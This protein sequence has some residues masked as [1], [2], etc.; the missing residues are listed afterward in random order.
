MV[1]RSSRKR[2]RRV[3]TADSVADDDDFKYPAESESDEELIPP[4]KRS[5]SARRPNVSRR[6][7]KGTG[8]NTRHRRRV[9]QQETSTTSIDADDTEAAAASLLELAEAIGPHTAQRK[10]TMKSR[11]PTQRGARD[12]RTGQPQ[13][14][15]G[16]PTHQ[17]GM[18]MNNHDQMYHVAQHQQQQQQNQ[19]KRCALHVRIAYYIF[20]AQ[21]RSQLPSPLNL[22][23][24][25]QV[26]TPLSLDP[27]LEA[28]LLKERNEPN[29]TGQQHIANGT[30]AAAAFMS[31]NMRRHP[32]EA[33]PKPP[34]QNAHQ[35]GVPQSPAGRTHQMAQ[36]PMH[37]QMMHQRGA[38]P[39][40]VPA[41]P[42]MGQKFP[43]IA[44]PVTHTNTTQGAHLPPINTVHSNFMPGMNNYSHMMH[45]Q[46]GQQ[47]AHNRAGMPNRAGQL[48][49]FNSPGPKLQ[50]PPL[51]TTPKQTSAPVQLPQ[52]HGNH[53]M[54][55]MPGQPALKKETP[56]NAAATPATEAY[57]SGRGLPSLKNL[58]RLKPFAEIKKPPAGAPNMSVPSFDAIKNPQP[59]ELPGV[60]L[61]KETSANVPTLNPPKLEV[62]Q[63]MPATTPTQ[64]PTQVVK[65]EV[66]TPSTTPATT[67]KP[68]DSVVHN[69]ATTPAATNG[70]N[71]LVKEVKA[72]VEQAKTDATPPATDSVKQVVPATSE[73]NEAAAEAP[74][75]ESV[76]AEN[77]N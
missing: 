29:A 12:Q 50:L 7:P 35:H 76:T 51:S 38:Q 11:G 10:T 56:H 17:Q 39:N 67:E 34:V 71:E 66:H 49:S 41:M 24:Q 8:Y 2:A 1:L 9:T 63:T 27:T 42:P 20:Y 3:W 65:P 23:S 26:M 75:A 4:T 59:A 32:H 15:V 36:M 30:A 21:K 13:V 31:N 43:N 18:A 60:T 46:Q 58:D 61:K 45:G 33:A 40:S 52:I 14:A 28:R 55:T 16:A 62:K 72:P 74:K 64:A 70:S 73:K 68:S 54:P 57:A 5:R 25:Q 48:P 53:N 37:G 47:Q 77:G 6:V 19:W 22:F 44:A 69:S